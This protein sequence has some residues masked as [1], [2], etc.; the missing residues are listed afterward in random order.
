VLDQYLQKVDDASVDVILKEAT[1]GSPL[2]SIHSSRLFLVFKTTGAPKR[3]A[4]WS[5]CALLAP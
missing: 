3:Q 5:A 1:A 4:I 2:L